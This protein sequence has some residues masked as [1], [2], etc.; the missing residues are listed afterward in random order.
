MKTKAQLT[1]PEEKKPLLVIERKGHTR[2]VEEHVYK[3]KDK[4]YRGWSI[5]ATVPA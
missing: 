1:L 4:R 5:K 3:A 2:M